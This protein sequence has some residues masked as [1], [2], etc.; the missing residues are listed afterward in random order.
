A[1]SIEEKAP[2]IFLFGDE[3]NWPGQLKSELN[4]SNGYNKRVYVVSKTKAPV[5]GKTLIQQLS[6]EPKADKLRYIFIFDENAPTFSLSEDIYLQQL[7]QDL[8]C[9]VYSKGSWGSF[10]QLPFDE[11]NEV[12]ISSGLLPALR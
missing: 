8:L 4:I 10:R 11:I 9:N 1:V 2:V 3:H 6:K 5:D 7:Q 12:P